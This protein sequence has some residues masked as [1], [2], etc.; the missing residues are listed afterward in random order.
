MMPD[1]GHEYLCLE[2]EEEYRITNLQGITT[3]YLIDRYETSDWDDKFPGST[4]LGYVRAG[5]RACGPLAYQR[6][7]GRRY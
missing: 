2:F 4:K 7:R 6:A 3:N 5:R 1:A